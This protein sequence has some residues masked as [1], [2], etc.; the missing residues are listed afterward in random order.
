MRA[1]GCSIIIDEIG[2]SYF[3]P[4]NI[5]IYTESHMNIFNEVFFKSINIF[6]YAQIPIN[7]STE[8]FDLVLI[9]YKNIQVQ[10]NVGKLITYHKEF[11]TIPHFTRTT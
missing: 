6:W 4:L 9:C 2:R 3:C 5:S 8:W 1:I 10:L 11:E 7:F